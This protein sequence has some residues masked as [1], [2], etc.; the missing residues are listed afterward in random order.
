MRYLKFPGDLESGIN[1]DL[2][3]SGGHIGT[4]ETDQSQIR[5]PDIVI[6]KGRYLDH[7]HSE[8]INPH[9]WY[10]LP[11]GAKPTPIV[12]FKNEEEQPCGI[13]HMRNLDGHR[14]VCISLVN[15]FGAWQTGVWLQIESGDKLAISWF[16]DWRKTEISAINLEIISADR[17]EHFD[18]EDDLIPLGD[19]I[20]LELIAAEVKNGSESAEIELIPELQDGVEAQSETEATVAQDDE[21][22]QLDP[23]ATVIICTATT[24]GKHM[25]LGSKHW[26]AK[27]ISNTPYPVANLITD[28][29]QLA[30]KIYFRKLSDW[31]EYSLSVVCNDSEFFSG[32]W[33]PVSPRSALT[34]TWST[35][36]SGTALEEFHIEVDIS[37]D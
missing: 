36:E 26:F 34:L 31:Y 25:R 5:K 9:S 14:S 10:Q 8:F 16:R 2:E 6:L 18:D 32:V 24:T 37:T 21:Q 1:V 35:N 12:V 20:D 11:L 27:N 4:L 15:K 22:I 7:W 30:G 33:K 13:V 3:H 17:K 19:E 29:Q 28:D 23:G